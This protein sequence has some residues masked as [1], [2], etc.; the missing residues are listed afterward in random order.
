MLASTLNNHDVS[1]KKRKHQEVDAIEVSSEEIKVA[2]GRPREAKI[3][4]SEEMML[5]YRPGPE[6]VAAVLGLRLFLKYLDLETSCFPENR[7]DDVKCLSTPAFKCKDTFVSGIPLML[8]FL[9][10]KFCLN[11]RAKGELGISNSTI[12]VVQDN[13]SPKKGTKET[14]VLERH[15]TYEMDVSHVD[16][17]NI[18]LELEQI[19]VQASHFVVQCKTKEGMDA[20]VGSSLARKFRSLN[21]NI[22]SN[23][24]KKLQYKSKVV[25]GKHG[26]NVVCEITGE[27][28]NFF[29]YGPRISCVDFQI[30]SLVLQL[31]QLF[32]NKIINAT[33]QHRGNLLWI[34]YRNMRENSKVRAGFL[35]IENDLYLISKYISDSSDEDAES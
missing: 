9:H 19:A 23:W 31:R 3:V 18:L 11:V 6:G 29:F 10:D 33:L 4:K 8:Y 35:D 26:Q 22:V 12:K 15:D 30:V 21:A 1:W 13:F 24:G 25:S 16:V 14:Q 17:L 28:K 27:N 5:Y 34:I 20:Y 7:C 2:V 32:G